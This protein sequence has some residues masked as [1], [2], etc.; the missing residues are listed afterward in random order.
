MF[1]DFH[2]YENRKLIEEAERLGYAGIAVFKQEEEH[3]KLHNNAYKRFRKYNNLNSHRNHEHP[4]LDDFENIKKNFSLQVQRGVEI[5]AKNPQDMKRKVQRFRKK[6]DVLT[7]HG[8]DLK[9]NRAACE[10]P[11]VDIICHPY[12]NR[13]DSGINHVSG[14]KAAENRVAVELNIRDLLKVR[15]HHRYRVLGQF[16]E[17]LKL[18]RKFHFP[19]VISSGASSIYDLHTPHDIMALTSCFGMNGDESVGAL[20]ETP[21]DIMERNNI[22]SNVIVEGVRTI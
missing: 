13:R 4:P 2:V 22:R 3:N 15:H 21:R 11:R 5:L 12:H 9:I 1:F 20:S 10:D 19:M 16:R 17:I 8:G 6:A 7:V 18:Q 14:R